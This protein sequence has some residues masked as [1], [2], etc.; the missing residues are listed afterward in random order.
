MKTKTLAAIIVSSL[1]LISF[2]S[3]SQILISLLL[4]DKLNTGKIEFGL[5]GGVNWLNQTNTPETK[6][7]FDWNLGFY[8]DIKMKN[9]HLFV[10]TGVIVKS[11]MG[12]SG[13]SPYDL[14][15]DFLDS[16]FVGGTVDRKINYFNV[17]V[18]LRYRFGN[19]IHLEGGIQ[20]GLRYTGFDVFQN[21]VFK[22]NDLQFLNEIKNDF[23][24]LDAGGLA[25]IGYKLRKGQGMIISLR[26]Y[27]GFVDVN[28]LLAGNQQNTSLYLTASIP[29]GKGKAE[30]KAKEEAAEQGK[31]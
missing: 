10:H 26:Y 17:P 5:D 29:I 4:G 15:D 7:L 13:I 16:I 25:G 19:F 24:R 27:Y 11:K 14:N 21:D 1:L 8:F 18:M 31:Q 6:R 20:L 23:T 2:K 9:P 22:K 30:R 28:K 3:N 12:A